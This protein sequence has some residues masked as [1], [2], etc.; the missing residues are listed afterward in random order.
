[1][2]RGLLFTSLA[3][4]QVWAQDGGQLKVTLDKAGVK[5][6]YPSDS[7][8]ANVSSAYNTRFTYKPIAVA[9][10]TD[11][12]Q[13]AAAVAAAAAHNISIAPRGGGHSYTALGLG[14]VPNRAKLRGLTTGD[15]GGADNALVI[16]MSGLATVSVG[17][18]NLAAIGGGARLGEVVT[19]LNAKGRAMPHGTCPHVG[20]GGHM[21]LGRF[22][23]LS[24]LRLLTENYS[25]GG[26]GPCLHFRR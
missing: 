5:A 8:Y 9:F 24:L 6:I 7:L 26:Y 13:V 1:M 20:A 4:V 12:N 11:V 16:D 23:R 15:T 10:P 21:S 19:V 22:S 2:L 25:A 18:D 14:K 17:D 3:F